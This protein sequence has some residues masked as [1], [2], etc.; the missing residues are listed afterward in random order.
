MISKVAFSFR[1]PAQF[2]VSRIFSLSIFVCFKY[3]NLNRSLK[4]KLSP[5][6]VKLFKLSFDNKKYDKEFSF[7]GLSIVKIR[8]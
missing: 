3:E 8:F 4:L 5:I 2:W 7:E 1:L 6:T